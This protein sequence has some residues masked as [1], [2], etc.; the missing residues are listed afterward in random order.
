MVRRKGWA[1][2]RLGPSFAVPD[3]WYVDGAWRRELSDHGVYTQR[4]DAEAVVQRMTS[5]C[6]PVRVARGA[7]KGRWRVA[8]Y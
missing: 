7:G 2:W 1:I 8:A 5:R 6:R 3:E 4:E